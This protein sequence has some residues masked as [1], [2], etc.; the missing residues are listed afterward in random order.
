MVEGHERE[1][2]YFCLSELKSVRGP[3]GVP[4]E[5]DLYWRPKT[6]KE[7]APEMFAPEERPEQA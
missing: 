4:I 1:L 7:I 6:L 5:R 2:G 3:L